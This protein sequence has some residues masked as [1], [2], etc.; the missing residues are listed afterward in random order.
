MDSII[1]KRFAIIFLF[2]A[3][4]K[5]IL[6][7]NFELGCGGFDAGEYARLSFVKYWINSDSVTI[8]DLRRGPGIPVLTMI[9]RFIGAPYVLGIEFLNLLLF[10]LL[11][12]FSLKYFPLR[13]VFTA[14]IFAVFSP[15]TYTEQFLMSEQPFAIFISIV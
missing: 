2:I 15:A 8:W 12:T 5:L 4:A 7:S 9:F 13:L 1:G 11:G 3:I 6:I 14:I 10:Y